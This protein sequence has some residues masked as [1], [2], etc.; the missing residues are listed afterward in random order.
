MNLTIENLLAF[1]RKEHKGILAGLP[2]NHER[3]SQLRNYAKRNAILSDSAAVAGYLLESVHILEDEVH[4]LKV[5]NKKLQMAI[6]AL[7]DKTNQDVAN[8]QDKRRSK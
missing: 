8:K 6:E 4:E 5:T 3:N 2:T 1:S 7:I